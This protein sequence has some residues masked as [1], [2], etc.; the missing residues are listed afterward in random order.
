MS[1]S[2]LI[3]SAAT[4]QAYEAVKLTRH[5]MRDTWDYITHPEQLVQEF[6]HWRI[7]A[8]KYPYDVI[9]SRH[10]MLVPKRIFG[11]LEECTPEEWEEYFSIR[12]QLTAENIYD[13]ILENFPK[14]RSVMKH[15]HLHLLVFKA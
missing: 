5:D 7:I 6:T 14:D 2:F 12:H 10:D 15:L 11:S 9:A 8:N 4:Q 3:R 13:C 1:H